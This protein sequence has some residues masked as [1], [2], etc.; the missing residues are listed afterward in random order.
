ML[1][2]DSETRA[3]QL[4]RLRIERTRELTQ[5]WVTEQEAW[6]QFTDDEE[7]SPL[8]TM[9][10]LGKPLHHAEVERRLLR[11]NPNF[12]FEWAT[13]SYH[14]KQHKKLLLP[15]GGS[16]EYVCAYPAGMVPE[17]SMWREQVVQVYDESLGDRMP[18]RADY[19]PTE[20]KPYEGLESLWEPNGKGV[21]HYVQKDPSIQPAKKIVRRP[22]GEWLRGYRTIC[23][24]CVAKRLLT[25]AQVERE[26]SNDN[27]PE[28]RGG[29]G[30]GPRTRPW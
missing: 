7:T 25:P 2:I 29:M 13:L 5:R 3:E 11:L 9:R 30:Y 24:I 15:R 8:N 27:T 10:K 17:R 14:P 4:R 18:D 12:T 26:F 23:L 1:V 20:W 22:F 21:G 6:S 19:G 28:W 16:I